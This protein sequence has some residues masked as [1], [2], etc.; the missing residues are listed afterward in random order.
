MQI[1]TF[2]QI[3]VVYLQ[4]IDYFLLTIDYLWKSRRS[5]IFIKII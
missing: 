2:L 1:K 3:N 5:I 4:T